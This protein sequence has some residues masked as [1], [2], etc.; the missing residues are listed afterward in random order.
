MVTVWT[1]SKKMAQK[2]F[3]DPILQEGIIMKRNSQFTM[4]VFLHG[5]TIRCHCPADTRIGDVILKNMACL[6]SYH[7][8]PKRKLKYT[9]EAVSFDNLNEA[10]KNWI[11]INLILSNRIVAFLLQTH[12]LDDMVSSYD[13][14]RREVTIGKFKLDFLVGSTYLE[15][16]TPLT[17]VNV[18]YG[19]DIQT[20]KV[21]PF[22][23]TGR[24]QKHILELADSLASHERAILLTVNQYIPT[25]L[26]PHLH[27]THYEEVKEDMEKAVASGIETWN[28]DLCFEPDG[29]SLYDLR[30]T[31]AQSL[32]F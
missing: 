11:G 22:S 17:T 16:K 3:F 18:K 10:H 19:S 15:V 24:F 1:V 7:D 6:V 23:S 4:D 13:T 20:K 29:V 12:Q 26:K 25:D 21:T 30:K 5:E 8:D 28:I 31:T 2:L 32:H 9:V 14:I 27:S